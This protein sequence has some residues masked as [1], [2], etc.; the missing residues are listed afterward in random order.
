MCSR[1]LR[2]GILHGLSSIQVTKLDQEKQQLSARV[3]QSQ[4]GC[5]QLA[6]QLKEI[7]E[8][9]QLTCL[10]NATLHKELMGLREVWQVRAALFGSPSLHQACHE[11][12]CDEKECRQKAAGAFQCDNAAPSEYV[13]R[14][15]QAVLHFAASLCRQLKGSVRSGCMDV[16]LRMGFLFPAEGARRGHVCSTTAGPNVQHGACTS[17][18]RSTGSHIWPARQN[19]RAAEPQQSGIARPGFLPGQLSGPSMPAWSSR[20]HKRECWSL[21]GSLSLSLAGHSTDDLACTAVPIS[22]LF[23]F[24]LLLTVTA[25]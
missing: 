2:W 24:S 15:S 8:R 13:A 1:F 14:L 6:L 20:I 25:A 5:S 23:F 12:A 7:R 16:C 3:L 22:F 21:G 10:T 19:G 11:A 9:W 4:T 17:R 18:K